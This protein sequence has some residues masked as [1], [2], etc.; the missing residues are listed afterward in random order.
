MGTDMSS[1]GEPILFFFCSFG[2][3]ACPCSIFCKKLF[4]GLR[5]RGSIVDYSGDV[6]VRL[7]RVPWAVNVLT[8][9][10]LVVHA[11]KKDEL[12]PKGGKKK[13]EKEKKRKERKERK[14]RGKKREKMTSV[15]RER[16]HLHGFTRFLFTHRAR[17]L[18]G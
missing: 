12:N 11:I 15:S 16:Q 10:W 6:R 3:A 8:V 13:K 18:K 4:Q 9:A 7:S 17:R 14:F 1:I 2:R 5:T